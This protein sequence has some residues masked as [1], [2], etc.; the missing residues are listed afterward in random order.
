MTET[1][2]AHSYPLK[3]KTL[4]LGGSTSGSSGSVVFLDEDIK[5][6]KNLHERR[7]SGR[8]FWKHPQWK[9]RWQLWEHLLA[10][11]SC[12]K[13]FFFTFTFK[14]KIRR[15]VLP[16][17]VSSRCKYALLFWDRVWILR[18]IWARVEVRPPLCLALP[19]PDP[20]RVDQ[21]EIT[22]HPGCEPS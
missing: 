9:P 13:I 17:R 18:Y 2:W 6:Y 5:I 16:T 1:Q 11:G 20:S 19:H 3:R 7:E 12:S 8:C 4:Y 22:L 10:F 14:E 15:Q 21:V